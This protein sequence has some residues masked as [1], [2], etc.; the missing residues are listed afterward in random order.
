VPIQSDSRPSRAAKI[1]RSRKNPAIKT[2][3]IAKYSQGQD[4]TSIAKDLKITR[5]T[6]RAIVNESDLDRHLSANQS[7]SLDLIP[8][9]IK[10]AH[11]RL[12]KGSEAMSMYVLSNTIWPLQSKT[13]RPLDPGLVLNIQ[14]LMQVTPAAANT[15]ENTPST[16]EL[17]PVESVSDCG[18]RDTL[19]PA[20]QS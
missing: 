14:N 3:V 19:D 16:I 15:P 4:K 17:K 11:D 7:V 1:S 8:S 13:S 5:N 20:K 9:A 12:E 6:V 10:V 2:Q 18:Q